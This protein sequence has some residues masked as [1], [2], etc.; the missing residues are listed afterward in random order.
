MSGNEQR[1]TTSGKTT[2]GSKKRQQQQQQEE[3]IAG[4]TDRQ[5]PIPPA[6]D[7]CRWAEKNG[8]PSAVLQL[9]LGHSIK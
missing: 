5:T 2:D 7:C 4:R 3:C 1:A 8:G 9:L 6:A